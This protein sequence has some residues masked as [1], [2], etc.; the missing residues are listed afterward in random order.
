MDKVKSSNKAL[1]RRSL[2]RENS[3]LLACMGWDFKHLNWETKA[4]GKC[5]QQSEAVTPAVFIF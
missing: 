2:G 5:S 1:R 3:H 4:E